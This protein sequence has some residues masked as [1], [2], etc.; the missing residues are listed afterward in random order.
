[1]AETAWFAN[2]SRERDGRA[3]R[4]VIHVERSFE[5]APPGYPWDYEN[6]LIGS[7]LDPVARRITITITPREKS[8]VFA[9]LSV[10]ASLHELDPLALALTSL[11]MLLKAL[12]DNRA[13]AANSFLMKNDQEQNRVMKALAVAAIMQQLAQEC[14]GSQGNT[15]PLLHIIHRYETGALIENHN[16]EVLL[17]HSDQASQQKDIV[18]TRKRMLQQT[19]KRPHGTASSL[20]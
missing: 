6:Y 7:G 17:R 8:D 2:R 1:M 14:S 20:Y 4:V 9:I 3:R 19:G 15:S 18:E 12:P 11:D 16:R 5:A 13:N 10:V